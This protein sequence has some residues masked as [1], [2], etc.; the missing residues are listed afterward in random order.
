M[1]DST[2]TAARGPLHVVLGAGQVGSRLADILLESGHRVRVVRR[3]EPGAASAIEWRRADLADPA[4]AASACDGAA[5]IYDCTNPAGY[6]S[7]DRTL[8]PLRRGVREAAARTGAFLVS[9]DNLY[10]YGRPD[11]L[12]TEDTPERPCSAKGELRAHLARDLLEANA[13]GE[14]RATIARASDFFGPGANAMAL[15]GERTVR[16]LARGGRAILLGDPDLPRSY[17]YV[18]DVAAGLALLGSRPDLAA[19]KVFHLPVAWQRGSTHELVARL[20]AELGVA[21]RAMRVPRWVF[22]AVGLVSRDLGAIA[23]MI[24]QWEVPYVVD[25]S[26]FAR[27]FGARATPVDVAI[28]ETVVAAGERRGPRQRGRAS[29]A[30]MRAST[31]ACRSGGAP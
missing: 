8:P 1:K 21:P 5:V 23:E 22:R 6:G 4:A 7:W 25:D 11:G 26:R 13:R 30:L 31:S 14:V 28:R 9:L 15:Y 29:S 12:I 2:Q 19:G 17:S 24:Y 27:T 10:V 3:G 20:A 16:A 18:P